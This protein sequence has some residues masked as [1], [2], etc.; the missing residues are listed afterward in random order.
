VGN[1]QHH[2]ETVRQVH[3][4]CQ[5]KTLGVAKAKTE[6]QYLVDTSCMKKW[7]TRWAERRSWVWDCRSLE[8]TAGFLVVV[9]VLLWKSHMRVYLADSSGNVISE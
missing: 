2:A 1:S 4:E 6:V 7:V 3:I 9:A 5:G 8:A